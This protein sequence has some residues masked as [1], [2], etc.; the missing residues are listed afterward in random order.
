MNHRALFG[1]AVAVSIG[2]CAGKT[3]SLGGPQAEKVTASA[4]GEDAGA[5]SGAAVLFGD[6]ATPTQNC[7]WYSWAPVP[8]SSPCEY[9][10]PS[11][12]YNDPGF[13]PKTWDPHDVRVETDG[14]HLG[15]YVET[16]DGCAG[17]DGWYY[18]DAD[19]GTPTDFMIC[20]TTCAFVD[21]DAGGGFIRMAAVSCQ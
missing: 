1:L 21:S 10:L 20:P 14:K 11:P 8:T 17:G 16:S 3:T 19:G 15:A 4:M 9:V 13:D 6:A 12:P 5:D 2:A 7:H 18:A